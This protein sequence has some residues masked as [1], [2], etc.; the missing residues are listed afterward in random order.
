MLISSIGC[1]KKKHKY[2]TVL[3]FIDNGVSSAGTVSA[4]TT[5][6]CRK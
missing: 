3:T 6:R 4:K 5:S 1:T 2:K